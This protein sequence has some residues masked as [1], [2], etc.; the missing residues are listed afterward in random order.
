MPALG[1]PSHGR[2]GP[3]SDGA[4]WSQQRGLHGWLTQLRWPPGVLKWPPQR[5]P[6]HLSSELAS[7][8][9]A[10]PHPIGWG[11]SS[12][13]PDWLCLRS[14]SAAQG[15]LPGAGGSVRG[16][17]HP[18][19]SFGMSDHWAEGNFH[20]ASSPGS[21][22]PYVV[23]K[24][25]WCKSGNM[26]AA[27]VAPEPGGPTEVWGAAGWPRPVA[28]GVRWHSSGPGAAALHWTGKCWKHDNDRLACHFSTS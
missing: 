14:I 9:L 19:A 28:T 22:R 1:T 23:L 6:Q 3:G 18:Q 24:L 15:Q 11:T 17:R 25:L 10:L 13:A 21:G 16:R 8:T 7:P 27:L 5:P 4:G 20:L 26:W 2:E 12:T